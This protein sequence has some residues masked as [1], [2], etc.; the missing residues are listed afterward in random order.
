ERLAHAVGGGAGRFAAGGC[1]A[2]AAVLACDDPH[3]VVGGRWSVVTEALADHRPPSTE[4]SSGDRLTGSDRA[5]QQRVLGSRQLI[6]PLAFGT[7][8]PTSITLVATST[9]ASRSAKR[10]IAS[11]LSFAAI[12]PWMSATRWSRN[13]VRWSSSASWTAAFAWSA[14]DSSTSGHTTNTW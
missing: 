13:S 1:Q 4:H 14:S 10:R 8:I 9:S 7:S 2:P 6:I 5:L 11:C 3:P 12:C